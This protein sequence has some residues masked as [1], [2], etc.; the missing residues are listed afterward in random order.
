MI[1]Q[2]KSD[3]VRNAAKG[4]WLEILPAI[5]PDLKDAV[6]QCPN[7]VLDPVNGGKN[8]DGFRL[9]KDANQTGGGVSNHDGSMPDGFSLLMWVTNSSFKE[10]LND[11]ANYLGLEG[12]KWKE[13]FTPKATVRSEHYCDSGPK[14]IDKAALKK[15]RDKLRNVWSSSYVLDAPES[16][17]GR[18]YLDHR[19]LDIQKLCLPG[20]S[21]TIRFHPSLPLWEKKKYVGNFPALVTMICYP[22][23]EPATI[24]R[25]YLGKDGKKLKVEVDGSLVKAKKLMARCNQERLTGGA[26]RLGKPKDIL[27]VSEGIETGL[28][29][30]Q[31][32]QEPVWPCV[33][34]SLLK[35]FTPPA[36]VRHVFIWADKDREVVTPTG[37]KRAG[38]DAAMALVEKLAKEGVESTIMLPMRDIPEGSNS[39]DWLDILNHEGEQGFP[40]HIQYLWQ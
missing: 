4:R 32:K 34:T 9:F 39:L 36:H 17:L 2:H 30:M 18:M 28:S 24:H 29:V 22:N 15:N 33:N 40:S 7:H 10:V 3:A 38:L 20:L 19:G 35:G 23:G 1:F 12:K 31:V 21:K 16:L 14:E 26:I 5:A 8:G 25:T 37:V 27:H 11:V 6:K 13:N